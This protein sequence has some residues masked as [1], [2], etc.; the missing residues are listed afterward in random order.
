MLNSM[1]ILHEGGLYIINS[2]QAIV[3]AARFLCLSSNVRRKN[4]KQTIKGKLSDIPLIGGYLHD[5]LITLS[6]NAFD[7]QKNEFSLILE[8]ICYEAG[9]KKKILLIFTAFRYPTIQSRLTFTN[10]SESEHKFKNKKLNT[11]GNEHRLIEI[12]LT[13]NQNIKLTAEHLEIILFSSGKT[14]VILE[15][16]SE[17]SEKLKVH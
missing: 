2:L 11:W 3:S 16:V 7:K 12:D 4:M 13:K 1:S 8:R 15:D 6:S 14:E 17:P 5:S 10:I 9:Q